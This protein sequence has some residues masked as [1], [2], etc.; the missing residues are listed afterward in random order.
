MSLVN[1]E[2]SAHSDEWEALV[3]RKP[4]TIVMSEE[5]MR[6]IDAEA[7]PP[8]DDDVPFRSVSQCVLQSVDAARLTEPVPFTDWIAVLDAT[9][10]TT[11]W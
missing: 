3:A 4:I 2:A 1:R 9:A 8:T 10:L 5:E 6:A 11:S 7:L